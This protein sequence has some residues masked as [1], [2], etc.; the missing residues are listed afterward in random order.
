MW[1]SIYAVVSI[2]LLLG[3]C[4]WFKTM[5][6]PPSIQAYEEQPIAP[7]AHAVPVGGLPEYNL[8]TNEG[9]PHKKKFLIQCVSQVAGI[10]VNGKGRSRRKAEQAA[11]ALALD[12]IAKN[13]KK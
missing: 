7:P 2:P 4:Q 12:F 5:S 11:A 10:K 3:G 13:S 8:L 9:P 6:D 1:R